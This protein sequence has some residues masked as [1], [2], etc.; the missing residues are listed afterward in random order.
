MLLLALVLTFVG[1]PAQAQEDPVNEHT[2]VIAQLTGERSINETG[3]KFGVDGADLGHTFTYDGKIYMVFGDTFG[4]AKSDWRSNV[5]AIISDDD[6]SDGLT[7]DRM[8]EDAPGH[9]KELLSSKKLDGDEITVIPTYGVAVGDR[10]Y[11]HY[12]SVHRWGV[13]GHW[14]LNSSGLAYSDDSGETW[15]KD[16]DAVWPGDSNFG[17]V[18]ITQVEDY[19]Y[20]FGIPGGRYGGVKLARMSQ[21]HLLEVD[22]YEY[23]DGISWKTG[24][25]EAG[26]LILP[27]PVGELSVRWNSHYKKW[28][29]MYLNETRFGAVL[30]TADCLTGPW[31]DEQIIA[32]SDVYPQLYA[33]YILALWND[34]PEIY[35]TMSQF[36]P[37]NVFLMETKLDNVIPSSHA[38]ECVEGT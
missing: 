16:Q 24:D 17:Q 9:A 27:A 33:P 21:D 32:T 36:G 23:W 26:M 28:I 37:Y 14:D 30:R 11:L 20:F 18:A 34:G 29:M 25:E 10:M 4:V 1:I 3:S 38:T 5:A 2:R 22:D 35:F 6:P 13:P 31:S 7:F 8:I 15:T 19:V 12:M